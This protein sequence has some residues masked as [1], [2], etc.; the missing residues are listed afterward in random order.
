MAN[1][2]NYFTSIEAIKTID[3]C[4]ILYVVI[5]I[6]ALVMT[7]LGRNVYRPYVYENKIDDF[8]IA[9]SIGNL[10]GIVVQLF[11]TLAIL[12]SPKQKSIRVYLFIM[13]GYIVYECLQPYL[14]KG[15]F[16][17]KDVYGTLIGGGISVLILSIIRHTVRNRTLHK[18]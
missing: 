12:N 16:D 14:P 9:D 11:F 6:I 13:G 8:G 2:S 15:V 17:W 10:G 4:R 3:V 1:T 7:E 5:A 18:F